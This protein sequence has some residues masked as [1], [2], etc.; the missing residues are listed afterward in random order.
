M[1]V[2]NLSALGINAA[3]AAAALFGVSASEAQSTAR[4][5]D[6]PKSMEWVNVGITLPIPQ[7][8]G[9]VVETF[10]TLPFGIAT[11][12][13][14]P[15]EARGTSVEWHRMVAAKNF[16]LK[17]IK[18]TMAKLEPGQAVILPGLEV[19]LKRTAEAVVPSQDDSA[20]PLLAAISAKLNVSA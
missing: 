13:L 17:H 10:V 12:N 7:A 19:Q 2:N 8:D 20:N 1:P 16:L 9:T 3:E 5:T 4:G 6:R 14:E 18:D 11:D 15:M